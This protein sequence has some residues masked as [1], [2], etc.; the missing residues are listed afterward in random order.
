MN[1]IWILV[2]D[3]NGRII[4]SIASCNLRSCFFLQNCTFMELLWGRYVYQAIWSAKFHT[5]TLQL[6]CIVGGKNWHVEY[7]YSLV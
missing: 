1:G 5:E 6:Y 4:D 7:I 3:V 2:L